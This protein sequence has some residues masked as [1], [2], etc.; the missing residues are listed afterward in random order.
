MLPSDGSRVNASELESVL[1][2]QCF[3]PFWE[4][5]VMFEASA[6]VTYDLRSAVGP[7]RRPFFLS[8]KRTSYSHF[9][10]KTELTLTTPSWDFSQG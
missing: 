2:K 6:W 3:T 4:R 10:L 7:A 1:V 9:E 8:K 5:T